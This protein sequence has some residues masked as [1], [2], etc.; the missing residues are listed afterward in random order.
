MAP[1][2]NQESNAKREEYCISI[3]P[4]RKYY[5]CGNTWVK[6]SLRATEWQQFGG[7]VY[8]PK[9]STQRI[10]NEGAC[11]KFLGE[12]TEIPLPKLYACFEDDGAGCLVTE[13]V[14]GVGMNDLDKEQQKTLKTLTLKQ[15]LPLYRIMRKSDGRPW[16]RPREEHSLVFCHNDLSA[17][18][19][20]VDPDFLKITAIVD[21]E[22]S[23]FF[24]PDFERDFYTRSGP[25]VALPG[26]V[27]DVDVLTG[28]FE[29]EKM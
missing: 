13:Y 4:E 17:N 20:I 14:E 25:S 21:W 10:L 12:K 8:V 6:R 7:F 23:G 5:R 26:D 15:V 1:P 16:M 28:I 22:Y 3:T 2:T 18:N 11:L 9:L 19:V 27:D 29:R 24:P